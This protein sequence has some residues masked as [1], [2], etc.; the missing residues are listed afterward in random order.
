MNS[1]KR[2]II[3]DAEKVE[4]LRE[5]SHKTGIDFQSLVR[6]GIYGVLY[7]HKNLTQQ[8]ADKGEK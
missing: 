6:I 3:A 2:A 8:D 4:K 1:V 7:R 5:L